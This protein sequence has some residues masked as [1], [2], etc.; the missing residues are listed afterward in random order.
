[1]NKMEGRISGLKDNIDIL[2]KSDE[3]IEKGMKK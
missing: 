1:L 2:E 3:C